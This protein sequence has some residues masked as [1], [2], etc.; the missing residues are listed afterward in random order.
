MNPAFQATAAFA[1]EFAPSR[2]DPAPWFRR[3]LPGCLYPSG[4]DCESID[5]STGVF[6]RAGLAAAVDDAMRGRSDAVAVSAIVLEFSDLREV[7]EIYGAATA[8]KVV[9]Q[10]VRRLRAVAGLRGIVGR[11][12]PAQFTVAFVGCAAARAI[13]NLERGLG[14]PARVEF[15]AGDSEIVLVPGFVV[16]ET[17]DGESFAA[18]QR[19]IALEL[20]RL[21]RQ[22]RRR[23]DYLTSERERYSRPMGVRPLT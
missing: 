6:N 16:D 12:G 20:A 1:P 14:K 13:R 15:D 8:R 2:R 7:R 17:E 10:V 18:L 23:L 22:E 9:A 3:W 19:R 4:G 11:T 5:R 21:Q